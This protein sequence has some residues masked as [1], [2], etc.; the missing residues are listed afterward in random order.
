MPQGTGD[1]VTPLCDKKP[2]EGGATATADGTA[3]LFLKG[4]KPPLGQIAALQ[5]GHR[6]LDGQI[7][8]EQYGHRH[9]D[10]QNAA[11]Q[12]GHRPLDGQ[13]AAEQYGH[14]HPDGQIAAVQWGSPPSPA[15]CSRAMGLPPPPSII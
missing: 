1:E 3:L 8:A 15:D 2:T 14:R 7:A 13:I 4:E 9:P 11:V 5:Y 10:G 12:Y 6:P